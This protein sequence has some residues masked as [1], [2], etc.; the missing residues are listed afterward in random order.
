[1]EFNKVKKFF[2]HSLK[3]DKVIWIL[4]IV[5]SLLSLV[6]VYSS[7]SLIAIQGSENHTTRYLFKQFFTLSVGFFITYWV[8]KIDYSW[9]FK[10]ST[11]ILIGSILFLSLT[12]ISTFAVDVN[13]ANRW[14]RL[15]GIGL[16][17]QPS[18]FV[19]IA[20]LIFI[21]KRL[22]VNQNNLENKKK[23]LYPILFVSLFVS[24]A[25]LISNFSTALFI[26]IIM[27]VMLFLGRVPMRQMLSVIGIGVAGI[28]IMMGV[29]LKTPELFP[30]GETWQKRLV[31][32]VP[33]LSTFVNEEDF[34]HEAHEVLIDNHQ[35]TQAKIAI[36]H[37]GIIG[38]GPGNGS[39]KYKLSQAYCDFIYAIIIEELGLV[40]GV[41]LMAAYL[42]LLFRAGRIARKC[43]YSFPALLVIG[44][45]FSMVF[46]AFIH[47]GV[48]VNL[49]PATG[50]NLP[51]VS[52]GGTSLFTTSISLGIILGISRK[53]EEENN[54]SKVEQEAAA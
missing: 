15:P 9:F 53:I 2:K 50:Q 51:I 45:M 7:V 8:H 13:N 26:I 5:L 44:L 22:S 49:L 6:A 42:I 33:S 25:V 3:G 47:I 35:V 19:K 37:G 52:L 11:L 40:I 54:T 17:F 4:L 34:S 39:Q 36:A 10:L 38:V 28:V 41:L 31:S 12:F 30:R 24:V 32:F 46:Q 48:T 43:D 23:V 16:Q 1:M 29:I 27:F 18:E 14:I 21:V 20:V